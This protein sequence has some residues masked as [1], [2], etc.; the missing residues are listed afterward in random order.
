MGTVLVIVI[1]VAL[2]SVALGLGLFVLDT[3][4]QGGAR[5]QHGS[6]KLRGGPLR[7]NPISAWRRHFPAPWPGSGPE[8][9][10]CPPRWRDGRQGVAT[11]RRLMEE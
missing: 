8:G 6:L 7:C 11:L 1:T 5:P 10:A 4:M 3:P 2:G 9:G